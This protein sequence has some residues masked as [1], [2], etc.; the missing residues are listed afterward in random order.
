MAQYR[1][2]TFL[3]GRLSIPELSKE[4]VAAWVALDKKTQVSALEIH[5]CSGTSFTCSHP[6]A[7]Q[8][9]SAHFSMM[10]SL[11]M[12][13]LADIPLRHALEDIKLLLTQE[14][15]QGRP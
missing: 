10:L 7:A 6:S 11:H 13:G 5:T 1:I 8:L 4:N 15:K 3:S 9:G 12:Q 14:K 2:V